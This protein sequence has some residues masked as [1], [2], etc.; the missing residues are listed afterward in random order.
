MF[1]SKKCE[2]SF[3]YAGL[4][5]SIHYGSKKMLKMLKSLTTSRPTL[6]KVWKCGGIHR[7]LC[8]SCPLHT[9][10][11][12]CGCISHVSQFVN[13]IGTS[14]A[15]DLWTKGTSNNFFWGLHFYDIQIPHY[16]VCCKWT[17]LKTY[18][19]SVV[20]L[21]FMW[22]FSQFCNAH[23]V[24][25]NREMPSCQVTLLPVKDVMRSTY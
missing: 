10:P 18:K 23:K 12:K 25:V 14:L 16:V 15:D 1:L 8:S 13:V 24:V 9:K 7:L 3:S 4:W 21:A 17:L 11:L 20:S 5:N 2:P 6:P 22:H 19:Q